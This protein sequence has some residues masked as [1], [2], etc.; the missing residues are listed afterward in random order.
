MAITY[1]DNRRAEKKGGASGPI[2][3][4]IFVVGGLLM[5]GPKTTSMVENTLASVLKLPVR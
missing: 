3:A 2:L 1:K 4:A 5:V